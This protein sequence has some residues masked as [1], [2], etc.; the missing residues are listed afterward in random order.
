MPESSRVASR[1]AAT[2]L[3]RLLC[4]LLIRIVL[5]RKCWL[6]I[7]DSNQDYLIQSQAGYRYPNRQ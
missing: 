2:L 1:V 4:C 7:L 5:R 6:A 3:T